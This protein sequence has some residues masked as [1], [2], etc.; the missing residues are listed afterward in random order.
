MTTIQAIEETFER[1]YED[2]AANWEEDVVSVLR[3]MPKK[4]FEERLLEYKVWKLNL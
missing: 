2:E 4:S 1:N 3:S